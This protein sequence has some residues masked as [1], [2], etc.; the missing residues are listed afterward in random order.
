MSQPPKPYVYTH[1]YEGDVFYVGKG[2]LGRAWLFNPSM[3]NSRW[4]KKVIGVGRNPDVEIIKE[5][6]GDDCALCYETE[7]IKE[8][9][10]SCNIRSR[11]VPEENKYRYSLYID[12]GM[13]RKFIYK[14]RMEDT[15]ANIIISG[16]IKKQLA[17]S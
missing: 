14:C 5:F 17:S 13:M 2:T 16:F 15:T 9:Q 12:K 11:E 4:A 3:R 10:P 8:L 6:F 7:L 1:S